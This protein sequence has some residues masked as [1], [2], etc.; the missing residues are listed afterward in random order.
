MKKSLLL[1]FIFSSVAY[2]QTIVSVST[3]KDFFKSLDSLSQ[4][5]T[6]LVADGMY[7][8][9]GTIQI[10]K[11]G[12][13]ASPILIKAQHRNR[14]IFI[15]NIRFRLKSIE[16]VTIEGFDFSSTEGP[17][18]EL[19]AC[20][21]VRITRNMFHLKETK[22]SSWVMITGIPGDSVRLSHSN[23]VDHNLFEK[24][25]VLGNFITIEGTKKANPQVSQRDR[26]DRN[27][28]RDIGPRVENVL[29]AIRVGS[30]EF[31][32]SSGYTVVEQNFFERCDG[33]PEYI[34]IKSSDDT[35][36]FNTFWECLGSFSLRHGNGSVV[37]G[38][39][40]LGNRRTGSFLDSTGKRWKLGTGGIRFYGDN[41]KIF[42]NYFE[43]LTGK[44][45]D[46]TLAI[47]NG[48]AIY[49]DGQPL[50]KH[51]VIRNAVIAFNTFVNNER[52][53]EIGYN[54][55]GFQ[56][57]WWHKPPIGLTIANNIIVGSQDT[58]IKMYSQPIDSKWEGNIA[59]AKG[60]AVVGA[61][62]PKGIIE[63][64]PQLKQIEGSWK[65]TAT[66]PAIDKA[67]GEYPFVVADIDGQLR[68]GKKDIG[69]DEFTTGAIGRHRLFPSDVGP[70]ALEGK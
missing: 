56:G 12:T 30:S 55:A 46:A 19:Q 13:A 4:G 14:A 50:T 26:I 65:P 47:T 38:N 51:F 7:E 33:D 68:V 16:Y 29:E 57:N 6:I 22:R 70:N 3:S 10:T 5:Q 27:H 8:L 62:V 34:S 23:R 63:I 60:K 52:N 45:W 17:A 44:E 58:L 61:S 15:G 24:K 32:L 41:M 42:N 2:G 20:N 64:D 49:G 53:I 39:Y 43:G 28:F 37:E 1:V 66:S 59:F 18:I 69:A 40:I 9:G 31:S 54:G 36:R 35:I 25:S 21:H 11:S 67:T 48:N